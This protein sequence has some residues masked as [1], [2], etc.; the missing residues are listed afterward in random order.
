MEGVVEN[1]SLKACLLLFESNYPYQ[2]ICMGPMNT[3][4]ER[5]TFNNFK[6]SS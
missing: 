6:F 1:K 3:F 2:L 5:S 4:Q